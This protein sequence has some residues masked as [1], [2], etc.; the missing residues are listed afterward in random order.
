MRDDAGG[1]GHRQELDEKSGKLDDVV[2][3]PPCRGMEVAGADCE[4]ESPI[5]VASRIEIAHGVND[6]VKT[7]NMRNGGLN[8]HRNCRH[9]GRLS[10][11]RARGI[12]L[13][14]KFDS[15]PSKTCSKFQ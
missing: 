10:D 13:A 7:A 11:D 15:P 6:M 14:S 9:K 5:E 3:G 12:S 4:P 8:R 1:I 2:F